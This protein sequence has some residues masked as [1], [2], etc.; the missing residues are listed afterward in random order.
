MD[1]T[2]FDGRQARLHDSIS[3]AAA[4]P[5]RRFGDRYVLLSELGSGG[6]GV[7]WVAFDRHLNRKVA[8][9][10][11][12]GA[13]SQSEVTIKRFLNE[14]RTSA[15]LRHPGIAGVY[16]VGEHE[17]APF[18][19]MEL[20]EG[21]PLNAITTA[22][23]MKPREAARIVRAIS[24]AIGYAHDTGV[25]HRDLKPH[26]VLV[27]N[28]GRPVVVDFGLARPVTA[29]GDSGLTVTGA[30]LGTP[31]YM[32]PEQATGQQDQIGTWS[33]VYGLGAVL[34]E[35]LTGRPPYTGPNPTV[36][37]ASLINRDPDPP[38]SVRSS[39]P[40]DLETIC[41]KAM[42]RD[43]DRRYP[44]A[45][46]LAADL[47]RY[48]DD[49]PIRA[50]PPGLGRRL[51]RLL[52]RNAVG[53]AITVVLVG[54]GGAFAAH[55]WRANVL[56]DR[57][58]TATLERLARERRL[59]AATLVSRARA[60]S[61]PREALGLIERAL[62]LDPGMSEAKREERVLRS[63]A[64]AAE[65]ADRLFAAIPSSL[66]DEKRRLQLDQVL[67]VYPEHPTALIDRAR[68]RVEL[69]TRALERRAG[70]AEELIRAAIDDAHAGLAIAPRSPAALAA[71][72]PVL[73]E[74]VYAELDPDAS[75]VARVEDLVEEISDRL[76][77]D[78]SDGDDPE[79]GPDPSA[80]V[81]RARYRL[82]R[83]L[84]DAAIDDADQALA[85]LGDAS[86]PTRTDAHAVRGRASL[87]LGDAR[88]AIDDLQ[89][90]ID[91]DPNR[92]WV[93]LAV[94]R[95]HEQVA[96]FRQAIDALGK[97]IDIAPERTIALE[98]RSALRR[99]RGEILSSLS[100]LERAYIMTGGHRTELG[101]MI[102]DLRDRARGG[103]AVL[104]GTKS[105]A[106][107]LGTRKVG[108]T[109]SHYEHRL[110]DGKRVFLIDQE[111]AVAMG[112]ATTGVRVRYEFS[113]EGD[114]PL[115]FVDIRITNPAGNRETFGSVGDD[116]V[117]RLTIRGDGEERQKEVPGADRITL[118]DA[119]FLESAILSGEAH[120]GLRGEIKFLN[121]TTLAIDDMTIEFLGVEERVVHGALRRFYRAAIHSPGKPRSE[122]AY[123]D[124]GAKIFERFSSM[125]VGVPESPETVRRTDPGAVDLS[126]FE[127][128]MRLP[129]E[130][131]IPPRSPDTVVTLRAQQL[132]E[133]ADDLGPGVSAKREKGGQFLLRFEESDARVF[134]ATLPIT[135]PKE[136]ERD[137]RERKAPS[138][139]AKA[140]ARGIIGD[141][142]R[143]LGAAGALKRW[144]RSRSIGFLRQCPELELSPQFLP[145]SPAEE[146]AAALD[147]LCHAAGIPTR[148]VA[149]VSLVRL[150]GFLHPHWWIEVWA[151]EWVTVDP[152]YDQM[153]ADP[154]RIPY[155]RGGSGSADL[156]MLLSV[157]LAKFVV[158]TDEPDAGDDAGGGD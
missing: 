75:L 31:V 4:D 95:A 94:A 27:E 131:R 146:M 120:A 134:E 41:C 62:E 135:V 67:A 147:S 72:L 143:V 102:D 66:D 64:Q 88:G 26:N 111:S 128:A 14:A 115:L 140:L 121:P 97:A 96:E 71:L 158:V 98:R 48:L 65:T 129:L 69:A 144:V 84:A 110:K 149:G 74:E 113:E 87:A 105:R 50:R 126:L 86:G 24:E 132:N 39:V 153:P 104:E 49:E 28:G 61:N 93:W 23:T 148:L 150:G 125:I 58:A 89:A 90:A 142:T 21:Q 123:D 34:Y 108:Y 138:E 76:L 78:P 106:L 47:R 1:S 109:L 157:T 100:D 73:E 8:L 22:E 59:E 9:K 52:R 54:A 16:D 42:E 37:I 114:G 57:E 116:G 43:P 137:L 32:A 63:R 12:V 133:L 38:R 45:A 19:A 145:A 119:C 33:D 117:L 154:I 136:R 3:E 36:V 82:A 85:L 130:G 11:L 2:R 83:G 25:L 152:F 15:S 10:V 60:S 81:V 79:N 139:A 91:E 40:K 46:A 6:A 51:A 124:T 92:L 7:V 99:S 29:D 156:A 70:G 77:D 20:I 107:F 56:A 13:R 122:A 80:L 141:E 5:K 35:C 17:G 30:V 155:R 151:G 18:I 68:V 101:P 103:L 55:R 127:N 44:S 118:R 112:P 53:V